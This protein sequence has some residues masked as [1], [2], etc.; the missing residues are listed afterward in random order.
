MISLTAENDQ[1]RFTVPFTDEA[2]IENAV[3][4]VLTCL[5]LHADREQLLGQLDTLPVVTMR[6]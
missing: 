3:C 4:A 6:V 5:Q 2:S 1:L